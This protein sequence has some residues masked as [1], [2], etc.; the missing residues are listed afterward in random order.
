MNA[1]TVRKAAYAML[2]AGSH[3]PLSRSRRTSAAITYSCRLIVQAVFI[4]QGKPGL[5]SG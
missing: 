2:Q 4:R 1:C 5:V 3:A